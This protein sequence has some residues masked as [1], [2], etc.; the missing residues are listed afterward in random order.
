MHYSASRAHKSLI[1]HVYQD[2]YSI[3]QPLFCAID[4]QYQQTGIKTQLVHDHR[5]GPLHAAHISDGAVG[6]RPVLSWLFHA[7]DRKWQPSAHRLVI[8]NKNGKVWYMRL[9]GKIAASSADAVWTRGLSVS[10]DQ[11][12]PISFENK[13]TVSDQNASHD[14]HVVASIRSGNSCQGSSL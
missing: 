7:S 2:I 6:E 10:G 8:C 11:S 13:G 1:D 12:R 4:R 3:L 5:Q 14:S 9:L